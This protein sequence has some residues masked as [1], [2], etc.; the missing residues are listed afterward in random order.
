MGR[1]LA[2]GGHATSLHLMLGVLTTMACI[3]VHCIV[4]TYFIATAKW[5]QHA[6]TVKK[7]DQALVDPT[8]SFR[9]Q[10][11]PAAL[12]AMLVVFVTA[13]TGAASDNYGTSSKLHFGLA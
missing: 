4:F 6:V 10:A 5:V 13:I 7:L 1:H 3:A 11:F 9:M 8:R 12:A 2:D